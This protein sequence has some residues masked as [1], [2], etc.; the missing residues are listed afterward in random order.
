MKEESG[1]EKERQDESDR[2][3]EYPKSPGATEDEA[4]QGGNEEGDNR[5]KKEEKNGIW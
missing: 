4:T 3:V 2:S 5:E 1:R